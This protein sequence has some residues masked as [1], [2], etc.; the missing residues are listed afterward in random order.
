MPVPSQS[1]GDADTGCIEVE[2][3]IDRRGAEVLGLELRRL[4]KAHG[5]KITKFAITP[6]GK[7]TLLPNRDTSP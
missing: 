1:D 2:V 7:D 4:A 5:L 6:V 3:T